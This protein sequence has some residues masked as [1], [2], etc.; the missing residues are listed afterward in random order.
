MMSTRIGNHPGLLTK[1]SPPRRGAE[2][3]IQG[4]HGQAPVFDLS[5]VVQA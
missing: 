1:T 3:A 5:E 4:V 2:G